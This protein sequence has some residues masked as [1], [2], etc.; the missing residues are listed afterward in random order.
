M[1]GLHIELFSR[2]LPCS[3]D[4]VA[5]WEQESS[6]PR[7]FGESC[8]VWG[9]IFWYFGVGFADGTKHSR[10]QNYRSQRLKCF[11]KTAQSKN[12][13]CNVLIIKGYPLQ[14][15]HLLKSFLESS[16]QGYSRVVWKLWNALWQGAFLT[17]DFYLG[18]W[19][20]FRFFSSSI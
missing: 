6:W 18:W 8:L 11:L 19:G 10:K 7:S 17:T 20:I 1:D 2:L 13:L 4:K 12:I 15:F 14:V 5:T 9:F 3:Q 16:W